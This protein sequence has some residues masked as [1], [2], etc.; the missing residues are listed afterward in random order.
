MTEGRL[1]PLHRGV[2]RRRTSHSA[3]R[4]HWPP[5]TPCRRLMRRR[6]NDAAARSCSVKIR[7]HWK[8]PSMPMVAAGAIDST[9]LPAMCP[10][11]SPLKAPAFSECRGGGAGAFVSVQGDADPS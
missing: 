1:Q 7:Q 10:R 5:A 9:F 6:T 3:P 8:S 2:D 4:R 11:G